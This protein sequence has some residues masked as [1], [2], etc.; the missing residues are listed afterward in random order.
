MIPFLP[1]DCLLMYG[2]VITFEAMAPGA[3]P[4]MIKPRAIVGSAPLAMEMKAAAKPRAG[5]TVN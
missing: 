4:T 1:S 5:M 2:N 3:H